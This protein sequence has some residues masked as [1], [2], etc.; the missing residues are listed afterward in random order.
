MG[1]FAERR[2]EEHN[3]LF[4]DTLPV[5]FFL[6]RKYGIVIETHPFYLEN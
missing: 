1:S 4:N 5:T 6:I 2:I 3:L